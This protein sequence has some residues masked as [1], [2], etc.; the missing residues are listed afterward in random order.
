[1]TLVKR[2]TTFRAKI[3]LLKYGK[4]PIKHICRES[5]LSGESKEPIHGAK[6]VF[7]VDLTCAYPKSTGHESVKMGVCVLANFSKTAEKNKT[8]FTGIQVRLKLSSNQQTDRKSVHSTRRYSN[9]NVPYQIT[10]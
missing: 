9:I 3:D 7:F 2:N 6:F 10:K 8:P 5:P 4:W 1:M